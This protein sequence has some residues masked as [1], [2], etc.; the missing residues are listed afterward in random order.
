MNTSL[1]L[2][3]LLTAWTGAL[4]FRAGRRLGWRRSTAVAT[5][6]LFGL[7][8]MAWPY[9]QGYF[10]DPVCAWGL[11]AAAYGLLAAAQSGRRLYLFGSGL[12]WGIA[13]LTRPINLL[14]LPIYLVG[15]YLVI[16]AVSHHP[17]A[18]R[19]QERL[20]TAFW[21][22]WR[23]LISFLIPVVAVGLLSLWW[24]WVRFGDLWETGYVATESFSANW[25][26]GLFGLTVGPA[27]G[28]IW[29][30][31]IL[32]LAIP[33]S[34][35]FWRQERR[36]FLWCLALVGLFVAVYA[37]WY[38]WHG[39]Y[40]WGPRFL[41]PI[42]PFLTLLAGP[43]WALLTQQRV[44]AGSAWQRQGCWLPFR[45]ASSGLACS[46]PMVSC[47]TGW[48]KPTAALCPRDLSRTA[49]LT[50]GGS[51][52]GFSCRRISIWPGGVGKRGLGPWIGS[53]WPCQQP[54]CW[55]AW[56]CWCSSCAVPKMMTGMTPGA[57]G[58]T[59]VRWGL[60]PWP[61]SPT[62]S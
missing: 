16:D 48:S 23:P 10:S 62:F 45:S 54:A 30:N 57:T 2:N 21:E 38:M 52:G 27:R 44:G 32:L 28:L 13:Y 31:P 36:L 29:Y 14:T 56:S 24:N 55:W 19:W 26:F 47:R 46:F 12:A 59:P 60:L 5:A 6:L 42:L 50:P 37:K 25:L 17:T 22:G 18:Q 9:T 8:T 33:G 51:S 35:W 53:G 3:P 39:G 4:L 11:F 58:S 20:R 43:G 34:L 61:C 7:G 49:I 15:L 1:L 41:V 40:S